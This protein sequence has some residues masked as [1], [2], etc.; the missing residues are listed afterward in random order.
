MPG[1]DDLAEPV[2]QVGPEPATIDRSS[3]IAVGGRDQP[4]IDLDGPR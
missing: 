2:E 4:D 1:K 3:E